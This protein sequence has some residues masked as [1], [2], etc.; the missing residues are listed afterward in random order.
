[1]SLA[2]TCGGSVR[3][4]A[5]RGPSFMSVISERMSAMSFAKSTGMSKLCLFMAWFGSP[6]PSGLRFI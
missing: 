4:S 5:E 3:P 2:Q 6:V 1:M